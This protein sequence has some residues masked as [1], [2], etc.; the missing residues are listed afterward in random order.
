MHKFMSIDLTINIQN[1]PINIDIYCLC[2]DVIS[3]KLLVIISN[4]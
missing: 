1:I 2:Y 4:N 3:N